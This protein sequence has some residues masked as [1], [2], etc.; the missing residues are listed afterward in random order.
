MHCTMRN[1]YATMRMHSA[2]SVAR[3]VLNISNGSQILTTIRSK[4]TR[5][6]LPVATTLAIKIIPNFD[7]NLTEKTTTMTPTNSSYIYIY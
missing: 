7:H 1:S 2:F 4:F 5:I 3:P 6:Q